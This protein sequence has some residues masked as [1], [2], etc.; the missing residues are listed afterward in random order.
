MI[1]CLEKAKKAKRSIDKKKKK[2]KKNY[3]RKRKVQTPPGLHKKFIQDENPLSSNLYHYSNS[4]PL[5]CGVLHDFHMIFKNNKFPFRKLLSTV[6][7]Q[8][9]WSASV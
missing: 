6:K 2:K 5:N 4:Q 1:G 8:V 9:V 3:A 7:C